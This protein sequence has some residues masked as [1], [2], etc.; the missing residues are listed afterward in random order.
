[1]VWGKVIFAVL[2]LKVVKDG[3]VYL[4]GRSKDRSLAPLDSS[5]SSY[6]FT[7]LQV[8]RFTGGGKD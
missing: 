2:I 8:Y 4:W 6:R 5:Y 3:T 7:G 1:M